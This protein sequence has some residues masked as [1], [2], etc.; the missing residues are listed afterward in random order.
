[1]FK[2]LQAYV[3]LASLT[4]GSAYASSSMK[5][6]GNSGSI[7]G[8]RIS[9]NAVNQSADCCAKPVEDP[10]CFVLLPSLPCPDHWRISGSF[11]Y[12][13]PTLDDTYFVMDSGIT[14][15]FP[16]GKRL[17][18]DFGFNP[19]F[20][21]GAEY[22]CCDT[23]REVQAFYSHLS[24]SQHRTVTG[25]HLWATLGC[26][27]LTRNFENYNG[28]A[29]SNLDLLY[30]NLELNL[31]QEVWGCSSLYINVQP[32][33]EYAYLRL[34][35][36][37]NYNAGVG[38]VGTIDQKSRTWGVGPKMGVSMDYSL[39]QGSLTCSSTQAFALTSRFSGSI[40]MGRGK[41]RNSQILTTINELR[42]FDEHTWRT[43]PALHANV[44]LS[45][46]VYTSWVGISL[47]VGYEFNTYVR[48]L[49]KTVFPDIAADGLCFTNYYN[50][51]IQGLYVT[52]ALSF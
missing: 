32:G 3:L 27:N 20:Q 48:A 40:L 31:S 21:V 38:G 41:T 29:S 17:N 45:Y 10:C 49:A 51:D 43:I 13:L 33:V 37:Y 9:R 23:L 24:A 28:T 26:P 34:E 22:A 36:D 16:N 11:L 39:Y 44:G 7:S 35:E 4:F 5:E 19:G 18:N 14:T 1:M 25:T 46:L 12:L 47:T 50:F 2:P 52:G 42:T 15:I 6:S 8:S 30:H